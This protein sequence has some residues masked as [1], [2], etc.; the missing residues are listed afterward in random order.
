MEQEEHITYEA[1]KQLT[2][3][4]VC[5]WYEKIGKLSGSQKSKAKKFLENNCIEKISIAEFIV[6][7][8]KGYNTTEH[9]VNIMNESCSCQWYV[10]NG[11]ECSHIKA[12]KL[13]QFM[14]IWNNKGE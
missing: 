1:P 3:K 10:K 2:P 13:F 6:H 9:K 11:L 14:D 12:V 7:P 4:T 8:I 5:Y